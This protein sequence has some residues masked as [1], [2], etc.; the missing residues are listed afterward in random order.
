[1]VDTK[2]K[3]ESFFSS[4]TSLKYGRD[5]SLIKPQ[6]IISHIFYLESGYIRQ[7][8]ISGEGEEITIHIFRPGSFFPMM[9]VLSNTTN[10]Y[11]FEAMTSVSI[12]K[13]PI[14]KVIEF[15]KNNP[16]VNLELSKRLS[17]GI[18]GLLVRIENLIFDDVEQKLASLLFYLGEHFGEEKAGKRVIKLRLTHKDIAT[19]IGTSRESVSRQMK[20]FE[21][22]KLL[23]YKNGEIVL[24][25][26][27]KI[28]LVV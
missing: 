21:K 25:N 22:N 26:P 23:S 3:L 9:L 18:A 24:I 1:M 6:D 11:Y 4:F 19:W 5:A 10:K 15:I 13:A 16:D 28:K 14:E 17:Q 7:Y 12:Y 20:Q 27:G 8:L 2:G